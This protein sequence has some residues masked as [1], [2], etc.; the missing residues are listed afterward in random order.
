[1]AQRKASPSPADD[2]RS[3]TAQVQQ[4]EAAL[5]E[6]GGKSGRDRQERLGRL[7]A[8]DRIEK[9]LDKE[10]RNIT[11]AIVGFNIDLVKHSSI[12]IS[13]ILFLY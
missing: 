4:Q 2:L 1:M 10:T 6:G 8:R 9:L 3:L 13:S 5:R 7:T 11:I 12:L